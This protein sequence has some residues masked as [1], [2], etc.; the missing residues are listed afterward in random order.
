V[1]ERDLHRV[2][3]IAGEREPLLP[4]DLGLLVA[5]LSLEM[6]AE[7]GD[8]PEMECCRRLLAPRQTALEPGDRF[9]ALAFDLPEGVDRRRQPQHPLRVAD[10]VQPTERRPHVVVFDVEVDQPPRVLVKTVDAGPESLGK[11]QAPV[12]VPAPDRRFLPA[13]GELLVRVGPDRL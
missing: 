9:V 12:R 13:G 11:A 10:P 7:P 1:G 8:H 2:A 5:P 4:Q 6:A 3:E